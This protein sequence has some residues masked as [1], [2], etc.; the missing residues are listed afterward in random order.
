MNTSSFV[1][2]NKIVLYN[3]TLS[4]ASIFCI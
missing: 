3:M 2:N 1:K 4:S